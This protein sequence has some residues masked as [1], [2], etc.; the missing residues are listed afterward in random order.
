MFLVVY[1]THATGTSDLQPTSNGLLERNYAGNSGRMKR[2]Q[3][4]EMVDKS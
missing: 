1:S 4:F 2:R 3:S